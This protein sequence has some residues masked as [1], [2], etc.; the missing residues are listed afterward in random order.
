MIVDPEVHSYSSGTPL[1][2]QWG[3]CDNS[4]C[5]R[6]ESRIDYWN[7]VIPNASH[8][9]IYSHA[10]SR[11]T[12]EGI[13]EDFRSFLLTS[14]FC[15]LLRSLFGILPPSFHLLPR[16]CIALGDSSLLYLNLVQDYF[17]QRMVL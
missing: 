3:F 9:S 14:E 11:Y 7:F 12:S 5:C 1:S 16:G 2:L 17:S 10:A 15:L 8:S 6:L 13:L 4:K